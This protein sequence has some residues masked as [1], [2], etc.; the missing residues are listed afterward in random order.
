MMSA[1]LML[2]MASV[3]IKAKIIDCQKNDKHVCE[4]GYCSREN[5]SSY[6]GICVALILMSHLGLYCQF[7]DSLDFP[8]RLVLGQIGQLMVVPFLFYS[9]FGIM[10]QMKKDTGYSR[11]IFKRRFLS[12]LFEYDC[13]VLLYLILNIALQNPALNAKTLLSFFALVPYDSEYSLG[14]PSWY[15]L[16]MLI[17][18]LVCFVALNIFRNKNAAVTVIFFAALIYM[19][20]C[21]L[22]EMPTIYANTILTFPLGMLVS[23]HRD[24]L[25]SVCTKSGRVFFFYAECFLPPRVFLSIMGMP[26]RSDFPLGCQK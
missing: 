3:F 19:A 15:I 16:D 13:A 14:I 12:V 9:G 24:F 4:G 2:F 6:K 11:R 21:I 17:M 1:I 18:Y 20:V 10:E 5:S 7:Q 26:H 25:E 23:Q 22:L 8:F